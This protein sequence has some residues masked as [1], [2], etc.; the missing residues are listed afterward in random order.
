[1]AVKANLA[2]IGASGFQSTPGIEDVGF[3]K[4]GV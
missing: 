2:N 1:V 4:E 3:L